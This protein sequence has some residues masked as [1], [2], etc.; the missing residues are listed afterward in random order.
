VTPE[1]FQLLKNALE[2]RGR[3]LARNT[4]LNLAGQVILLMV[5]LVTIPYVVRALGTARFGVLSI[6]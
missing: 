2:I 5:G 3:L 1:S 4:L 6:A